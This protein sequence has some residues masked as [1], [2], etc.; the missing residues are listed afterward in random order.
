VPIGA[1]L[2][3]NGSDNQLLS[4]DILETINVF[5]SSL[6]GKKISKEHKKTLDG[7]TMHMYGFC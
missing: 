2:D 5:S 6:Y 4:F 1:K 3:R 7:K